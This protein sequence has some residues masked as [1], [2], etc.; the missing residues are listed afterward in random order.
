MSLVFGASTSDRGD[1]G[2]N[3]VL[4][5]LAAFT[6]LVWFYLTTL[7]GSRTLVSKY[8]GSTN[9]GW[10]FNLGPGTPAELYFEHVR[11]TTNL[12]YHTSDSPLAI[13]R[14]GFAAVSLV[15]ATDETHI[16]AGF[17]GA[18]GEIVERAYAGTVAGSGAYASDA[19][20]SLFWGNRNVASPNQAIQGR[21]A[22]G[23]IIARAIN[24]VEEIRRWAEN[25]SALV[26]NTVDFHE[27][28]VAGT[29]TS[30]Q[31]DLSGQGNTCV[32]T[33]TT[34]GEH[35]PLPSRRQVHTVAALERAG[36]W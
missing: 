12:N 14:W 20:R 7:T 24:D 36:S 21:L 10:T 9:E 16:Y 25:P 23:G 8:R 15:K 17:H 19:A 26:P 27:F 13:G 33:G 3:A 32:M 11:A 4:D 5:D 34:L 30:N 6:A 28:G 35:I 2:S 1:C 31:P 29:G 18:G 22:F